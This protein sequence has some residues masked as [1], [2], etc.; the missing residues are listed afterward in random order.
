VDNG[1]ISFSSGEQTKKDLV[2]IADGSHSHLIEHI[3]GRP[4]PI[5]KAQLSMYRFLQPFE[6]VLAHPEAGKFYRDQPS[7]FTTFYKTVVGRPGHMM[8]TY[9]CR[10]GELLYVALLHPTKPK[11][12]DLEGWNSPADYEDVISDAQGFNPAVQAICEGAT[13]VKVY[14]QMWRD[15]VNSFVKGKAIMIGDAA[16]LM[17]PTHGQGAA[18]A[19]EDA[20]ALEVLFQN[21]ASAA[22]IQARA[23]V[24]DK[25]RVPRVAAS[26]DNVEQDDGSTG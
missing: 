7:G 3:I 12:K 9:P 5:N 14:T 13:D 2:I 16:H 20:K 17:L 8:N 6:K 15:A 21:I 24:F 26:T 19:F 25:L 4:H 11:E 22:D 18:M 23:Q 1:I 10:G